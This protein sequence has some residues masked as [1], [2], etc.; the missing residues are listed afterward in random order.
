MALLF[1]PNSQCFSIHIMISKIIIICQKCINYHTF[2]GSLPKYSPNNMFRKKID[3]FDAC[4]QCK[5][6]IK[7]LFR[8]HS[9]IGIVGLL[10]IFLFVISTTLFAG[11]Y[12]KLKNGVGFSWIFSSKNCNFNK[13][14]KIKKNLGLFKESDAFRVQKNSLLYPNLLIRFLG[15]MPRQELRQIMKCARRS[16]GMALLEFLKVKSTV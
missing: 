3:K 8:R 10:C 14:Q 2:I 11:L 6:E 16:G 9:V 5:K 7:K 12:F 1:S 13:F 15:S 4:E